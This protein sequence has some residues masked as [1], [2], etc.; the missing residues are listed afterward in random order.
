MRVFDIQPFFII[1]KYVCVLRELTSVGYP[2]QSLCNACGIRFKKEERRATATAAASG[3]M[4]PRPHH[5]TIINNN[6]SSWDAGHHSNS[7]T[8]PNC[9]SPV[10][11]N[12]YMFVDRPSL[13][14]DYFNR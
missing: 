5:H 3:A 8:A 11:A 12:E 1:W 4:D 6:S 9:F 2:M 13:V 7:Q 10:T 14:H